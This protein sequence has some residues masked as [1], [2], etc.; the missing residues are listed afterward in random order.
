M[1]DRSESSLPSWETFKLYSSHYVPVSG[2]P[3]LDGRIR[4][5]GLTLDEITS[6]KKNGQKLREENGGVIRAYKRISPA[7]LLDNVTSSPVSGTAEASTVSPSGTRKSFE[8]ELKKYPWDDDDGFSI[9][10]SFYAES[11]R[12]KTEDPDDND[13]GAS[14]ANNQPQIKSTNKTMAQMPSIPPP[15]P[16]KSNL[17]ITKHIVPLSKGKESA[18]IDQMLQREKMRQRYQ[19]RQQL[20]GAE[21]EASL[22]Q[23][24]DIHDPPP[25]LPPT[26]SP[27]DSTNDE[28]L[29]QPLSMPEADLAGSISRVRKISIPPQANQ[30]TVAYMERV[31]T[32]RRRE[33]ARSMQ[34]RELVQGNASPGEKD[35]L[36]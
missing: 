8:V 14:V 11:S 10:P 12:S 32:T 36:P 30:A 33:F 15:A 24:T 25:S 2:L 27:S 34:S 13:S 4:W 31:D 26:V 28:V 23:S 19:N 20:T 1:I 7:G 17:R 21:A 16:Q 9:T 6:Q 18:Y 22:G 5:G 35:P 3:E 29:A